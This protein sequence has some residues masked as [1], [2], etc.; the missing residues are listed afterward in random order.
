VDPGANI[1]DPECVRIGNNVRITD[2]SIFGHDGSV[3]MLNRAFGKRLDNVG[4]VDIRDNVFIGHAAIVQ[5][6]VT[7]GPNA[8]VAAGAVVVR[9]VPEGT[10]VGGVPAKPVSTVAG[11]LAR[12]EIRNAEFPWRTLV[13]RRNGEF[14][15]AI[16]PELV[17][18]RVRHFLAD[19]D[20]EGSTAPGAPAQ[21][22]PASGPSRSGASPRRPAAAALRVEQTVATARGRR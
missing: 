21:G 11:V 5:P 10:V 19:E 13:E 9:D 17:R 15:P 18:M 12:L 1:P 4:K 2:F 22:E 8:I 16:E 20:P 7:I 6:G 3:A 14:D